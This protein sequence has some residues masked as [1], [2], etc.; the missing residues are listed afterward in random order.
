MRM[1]KRLIIQD[2]VD[3]QHREVHG[4]S[5]DEIRLMSPERMMEVYNAV[6]E[7]ID[8]GEPYTMFDDEYESPHSRHGSRPRPTY[9]DA[10]IDV[11][12][13]ELRDEKPK[14]VS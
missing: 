11:P 13:I 1:P 7:P 8:P 3:P 6:F 14:L 10:F 9:D 12:D 2:L 4:Y 5:P